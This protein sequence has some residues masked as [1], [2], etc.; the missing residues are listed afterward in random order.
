MKEPMHLTNNLHEALRSL[1]SARQRSLLAL[2]GVMIG[3]GAVI[4]M[5]TIGSITQQEALQQFKEMGTDIITI[6]KGYD[7]SSSYGMTRQ[8]AAG[9]MPNCPSIVACAPYVSAFG[10][11]RFN[12]KNVDG[13]L[14]GVTHSF[15]GINKLKLESGRFISDL[16]GMM[17]YAVVGGDL[18]A[19]LRG[20]GAEDLLNKEIKYADHMFRIIGV[21]ETS[22]IN[23]MRPYEINEGLMIPLRLGL[24]FVSER[25]L[26]S[27]IARKKA[28]VS[29]LLVKKQLNDYFKTKTRVG[30]V[31]V[32]SAEELI[33]QMKKQMRL[34]T[35]LLGSIGGIAL[36]VGGVGVM[37]VMLVSVSE[38]R[39]EI[40]IR[41]ALGATQSDIQTQFLIESIV[42]CLVGGLIG[43]V[44]GL[45]AAWL[46]SYFSHWHFV[47]SYTAVLLGFTVAGI[48]GMFFGF[49]PARQASRLR[50]IE[51][52][53]CD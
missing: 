35:L 5:L 29:P 41:R 16:D 22:P 7:S 37:N 21:L 33:K 34:F 9:I 19:M 46:V 10:T 38:R 45:G 12:G 18:A 39:R 51:A 30:S 2:L 17:H 44:L 49:Y 48:V 24:R 42:L 52:L 11:M 32:M 14:L 15:Q 36:I 27:I 40:G 23:S 47:V 50:A 43:V 8:D 4:A 31:E 28:N 13:A 6:H 1:L 26:T 25:Y 53:R 3:V 20:E